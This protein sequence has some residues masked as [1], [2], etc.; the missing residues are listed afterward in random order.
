MCKSS[1]DSVDLEQC[2]K[3]VWV[4][5]LHVQGQVEIVKA[6]AMKETAFY[7]YFSKIQV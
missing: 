7:S 4:F 6:L 5:G 1:R 3:T 2:L